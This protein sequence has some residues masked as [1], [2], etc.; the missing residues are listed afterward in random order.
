[1]EDGI[2][3]LTD[4]DAA[5]FEHA[6][7]PLVSLYLPTHGRAGAEEDRIEFKNLVEE[8]RGKLAQEFEHREH[9]GL[10]ARLD[11][12]ATRFEELASPASGGSLAVLASNDRTYIYQ[13]GY[14]VGPLAFVGERFYARPLLRNF[15]FGSRYFLLGLSADRFAL[16]RGDFGSLERVELPADVLDEFSEEFPLVYDGHEGALDYSSL[17]NH[18]PP[19]HGWKS[20]ND[21]RKEEAGK[22]FQHVNKAVTDY[23]ATETGLPVILVSLPEHQT[24]FRRISTVPNLLDEGVEKDIGGIDAPELLDAAKAVIEH[25]REARADALLE[26]LGDAEPHGGGSTDLSAIGLA[27]VERKVRALFAAEGA[28]IPGGFDEATG[29]VSLFEREPHGRFQGPELADAFARAAL[30]QDAEVFELPAEKIPGDTG[31]AALYRY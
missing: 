4:F 11:E 10:D 6:E 20:R 27:L 3:V 15:Q 19:Y 1:M 14:E 28:Y 2:S 21:V 13:P 22:F 18:L 25:A 16:V 23:L 5:L 9:T 26:K 24:A 17:E 29:E 7:P 8:A 12:V 31:M 30:A